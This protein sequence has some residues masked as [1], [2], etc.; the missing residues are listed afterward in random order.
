MDIYVAKYC[1]DK[2]FYGY[3]Y[4]RS[5]KSRYGD[6]GTVYYV[7]KGKGN[8]AYE[9]HHKGISI[10]KDKSNIHTTSLMNEA[11]AFQWE[12]FSNLFQ[13]SY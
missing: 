6:I 2:I 10:P 4:L 13:R 9:K 8:R 5:D 3:E 12:N 7:G 1:Q 11:D